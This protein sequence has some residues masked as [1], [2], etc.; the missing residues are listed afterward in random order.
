M[1]SK[2]L[3]SNG[4]LA[5]LGNDNTVDVACEPSADGSTGG[6]DEQVVVDVSAKGYVLAQ[7]QA[8]AAS[9]P[10]TEVASAV[11]ADARRDVACTTSSV[12][13]AVMQLRSRSS[14]AADIAR[15]LSQ[16]ERV[17]R[18]RL[19]LG[20]AR[21]PWSWREPCSLG[22]CSSGTCWCGHV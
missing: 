3:T 13:P 1:A 9:Q 4:S 16:K 7:L 2:S 6:P 14:A 12:W 10:E 22:S 21:P 5:E 8:W 17:R 15:C 19:Q 11:V 18:S 20:T